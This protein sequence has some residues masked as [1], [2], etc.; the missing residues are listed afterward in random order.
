M[1]TNDV[2]EIAQ[3]RVWTGKKAKDLGLVDQ[4]GSLR[5]VIESAANAEGFGDFQIKKITPQL[6]AVD[7]V[8]K[9]F[10]QKSTAYA[11]NNTRS[12]NLLEKT[13]QLIKTT[14][15]ESSTSFLLNQSTHNNNGLNLQS[16]AHCLEC[17]LYD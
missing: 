12:L 2:H 14:K 8:L 7:Q 11:Q 6:S 15:L 9:A 17:I 13:S 4:L 16:Y 3:G 1:T 5:D 10:L